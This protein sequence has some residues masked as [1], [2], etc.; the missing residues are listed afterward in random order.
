MRVTKIG[1]IV[2]LLLASAACARVSSN[3]EKDI[4]G[5]WKAPDSK[6]I[7]SLQL[8]ADGT[9]QV[10]YYFSPPSGEGSCKYKLTTDSSG[11]NSLTLNIGANNPMMTQQARPVTY[12]ATVYENRL[13][14]ENGPNIID[15]NRSSSTK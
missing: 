8:T 13:V 4:V 11:R 12:V 6:T 14:L 10:L 7:T 9:C 15:M 5:T 3:P 1:I 2:F